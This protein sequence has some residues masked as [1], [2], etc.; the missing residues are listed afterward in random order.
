M[1]AIIAARN[2]VRAYRLPGGGLL[3]RRRRLVAV[4]DVSLELDEGKT[5]G[6]VGESGSGKSTLARLLVGLERPDR[7]TIA[8]DG[9]TISNLPERALR[10]Y[11]RAMQMVF[12]D[13]FGSLD[14]RMR[15]IDS[16]AEP[17]DIALPGLDRDAREARVAA[18]LAE[19]GLGTSALRRYPHQF[20]GGQR[21][22]IAIARALITG[23]RLLVADEPVSALDVSI[24]AQILNL[25]VDLKLARGL[26]IIFISH[27]L[28]V[29]RYLSDHV[30][31]MLRGRIVETGP[32]ERV[33]GAPEHPYTRALIAAMPVLER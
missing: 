7:G 32:T 13:P 15:V 23:P 25:L 24:Q 31:V 14:P 19:V 20:S 16:V 29:I 17:L 2:L 3:G 21:Q 8:F 1:T 6:I 11:R 22:R 5:L 26:S 10:P 30:A 18:T 4:D 33:F 28:G 27:N 12:Q 9:A